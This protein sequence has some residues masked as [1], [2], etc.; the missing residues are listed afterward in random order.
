M[1]SAA[2]QT[3]RGHGTTLLELNAEGTTPVSGLEILDLQMWF[4]GVKIP[5]GGISAVYCDENHRNLG[6]ARACMQFALELQRREGKMLSFLFG[7]P[8]FY[9]RFGYTVVMPWYAVY[10]SVEVGRALPLEPQMKNADD[11]DKRSAVYLYDQLVAAR[12]GPVARELA[13]RIQPHKTVKWW[14]SGLMR[15]LH[16]TEGEFRGYVWHSDPGEEEFEV[17]EVGGVDHEAYELML[18]YLVNEARRRGKQQIVAALPPDDPF[19]LFLKRYGGKFVI[20][21]RASGGGM[22]KIL[23]FRELCSALSP[24]FQKR[25]QSFKNDLIPSRLTL[26]TEASEGVVELQ[27]TGHET[28]LTANSAEMTKLLFGYWDFPEALRNGI[29]S[30]LSLEVGRQLFIRAYPFM[31][32]RDRF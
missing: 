30:T 32:L 17:V 7:I 3:K 14:T 8:G 16:G 18:A 4:S 2:I 5:V 1:T 29:S 31:Y 21:T 22:A 26:L 9:E 23:Q 12:I 28:R 19:S 24:V 10:V 11:L 13:N 27:G 20:T 25:V 6:Y 15:V